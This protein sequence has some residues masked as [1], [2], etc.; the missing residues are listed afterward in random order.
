[1][2]RDLCDLMANGGD[3]F[4]S[5][6]DYNSDECTS[7]E[8]GSR[9]LGTAMT[10]AEMLAEEESLS[11]LM[12]SMDAHDPEELLE[13]MEIAQDKDKVTRVSLKSRNTDA[14]AFEQYVYAK[15]GLVR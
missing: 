4:G 7:R 6:Y 1:M 10:F 8:F 11:G 15:C 5:Q 9:D 13:A 14:P 3:D 12:E 2:E